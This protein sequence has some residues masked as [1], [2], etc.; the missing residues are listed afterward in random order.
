MKNFDSSIKQPL[1]FFEDLISEGGYDQFR[2]EFFAPW[3]KIANDEYNSFFARV[4]KEEGYIVHDFDQLIHD[5]QYEVNIDRKDTIKGETYKIP[6]LYDE[7]STKNDIN[8]WKITKI[9]IEEDSRKRIN[10]K[11]VLNFRLDNEYKLSQKFI[12]QAISEITFNG[13][14][15]HI[16]LNQ[17]L[18]ILES[19]SK[20]ENN[21]FVDYPLCKSHIFSLIEF[22]KSFLQ[23]NAYQEELI[24]Q[25]SDHK[26]VLI[27]EIFDFWKGTAGLNNKGPQ[28]MGP[29]EHER[30]ILLIT[31]MVFSEKLPVITRKF[32][33]LPIPK[34]L[35]TFCFYVL[36]DILYGKQR[37][38]G[39][40]IDFLKNAFVD[41]ADYEESTLMRKFATPPEFEKWFPK[42][43]QE[44]IT[45]KYK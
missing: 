34:A 30:L 5:A 40:F 16:F 43:I 44:A 17:Q 39:Y 22:I 2:D 27:H 41:L 7:I 29:S 21:L 28:I 19:L 14:S 3:E 24:P 4:Y 45:N 15:A 18:I 37:G 25:G 32:G 20:N 6:D 12:N 13:N 11:D 38:K 33:R 1:K 8:D 35:I 23:K 36:K 9:S 26:T 42:I 10:L 31:E